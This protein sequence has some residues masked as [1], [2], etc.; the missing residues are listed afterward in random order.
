MECSLKHH[1][2]VTVNHP[3][4]DKKKHIFEDV[5]WPET[6]W[7]AWYRPQLPPFHAAPGFLSRRG[8]I[9]AAAARRRGQ[10]VERPGKIYEKYPELEGKY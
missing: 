3:F 10:K 7:P 2:F 4:D 1:P 5:P 6:P 9:A 8:R